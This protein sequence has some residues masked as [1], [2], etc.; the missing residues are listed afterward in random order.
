MGGEHRCGVTGPGVDG[1]DG[2]EDWLLSWLGSIAAPAVS[3]VGAPFRLCASR[4]TMSR[5]VFDRLLQAVHTLVEARHVRLG[6]SELG[7][8]GG[9]GGPLG[10]RCG[11]RG[12]PSAHK[13]RV[14][15]GQ[16]LRVAARVRQG[17]L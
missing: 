13:V 6:G 1:A 15:L 10:I 9:G 2:S 3:C 14:V 11:L 17:G 5:Q 16:P 7:A 8:R 4:S 12:I